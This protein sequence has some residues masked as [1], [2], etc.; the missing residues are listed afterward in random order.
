MTERTPEWFVPCSQEL[1][2]VAG[3]APSTF[4]SRV[5][6]CPGGQSRVGLAFAVV[7]AFG[8]SERP[9]RP[10]AKNCFRQLVEVPNVEVLST[11][12]LY[13]EREA[14]SG[15]GWRLELVPAADNCIAGEERKRQAEGFAS[16][17]PANIAFDRQPHSPEHSL[18]P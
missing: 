18:L 16:P 8:F 15:R 14:R 5:R 2:F 7:V 13:S 3:N 1:H 11:A 10:V 12:A 17:S 4:E 6:F 9:S